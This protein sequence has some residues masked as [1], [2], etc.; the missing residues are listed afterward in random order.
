M[1]DIATLNDNLRKTFT[2]GQVLLTA[3]ISA[4]CS[5]DKATIMSLV[6]NFN[7]FNE[8]NDPYAE[9]DFGSFDYKDNKIF[10]KIDY[11]DRFNSCFASENPADPTVTNRV[12]TIM[13][14][15]EY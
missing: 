8:G 15:D 7:D 4:M 6:Q 14:A 9:H 5:E 11:Y 12:M 3:S 13:L 10:W 1:T 2:G